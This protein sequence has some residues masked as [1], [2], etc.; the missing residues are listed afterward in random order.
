MENMPAW[1]QALSKIT[2][3]AWGLEGFTTL[4]LGGGLVDILVP[5]VALLVMGATLFTAAVLIINRRGL[6]QQ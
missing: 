4:A 1:F 3:N 6:A 5:V 2:P